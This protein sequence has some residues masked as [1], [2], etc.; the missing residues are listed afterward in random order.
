MNL[1]ENYRGLIIG[2]QQKVHQEPN[3]WKYGIT[4]PQ[5]KKIVDL[6]LH[7]GCYTLGYTDND[8]FLDNVTA[9]LKTTKPEMAENFCVPGSSLKINHASYELAEKLYQISGGYRS[10]FALSGSDANEGAIKLA[11]AYHHARNDMDR[12]KIAC[13]SNSYHGSTFLTASLSGKSFLL[14]P[15]YTMAPHQDVV[16]LDKNFALDSTDWNQVSCIIVET[17]SWGQ[18]LKPFDDEFWEK[19]NVLQRLGV[20]VILDDIFIGGGKTGHFIGWKGLPI[21]PDIFTMGK[22]ITAGIHPLSVTLYS[23]R[24]HTALP[25]YFRWDHGFTYSFSLPGIISVLE[26]LKILEQDK[27]LDNH[28]TLVER[29]KKVFLQNQYK[30][31][32]QFGLIFCLN[33]K[34]NKQ[35]LCLIPINANDEY[36]DTLAENLKNNDFYRI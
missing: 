14:N 23:E 11:S 12:K 16:T 28:N 26:Y 22:G 10:V 15:F 25:K 19:I 6:L 7:T 17:C 9:K 24:I 32:S 18:S 36:F 2:H 33:N 27:L 30:I 4:T 8:V 20:V 29:A 3:Y 21:K 35:L 31:V 1:L 34:C 13:I 5:G